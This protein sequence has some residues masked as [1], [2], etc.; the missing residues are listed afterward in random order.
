MLA[1]EDALPY[2]LAWLFWIGVIALV[3]FANLKTKSD[4]RSK[5]EAISD[6]QGGGFIGEA[7]NPPRKREDL[8]V[9]SLREKQRLL[10]TEASSPVPLFSPA[11]E[12]RLKG[13]GVLCVDSRCINEVLGSLDYAGSKVLRAWAEE[14]LR[15]AAFMPPGWEEKEPVHP[16]DED[17]KPPDWD[18]RKQAVLER[19]GFACVLCGE[20]VN[21]ESAFFRRVALGSY[22]ADNL[23]TLCRKCD[24]VAGD[25]AQARYHPGFVLDPRFKLYHVDVCGKAP[26]GGKVIYEEPV[27]YDQ[28]PECL[29]RQTMKQY[30]HIAFLR[31]WERRAEAIRPYLEA[32][33]SPPGDSA[34]AVAR[35]ATYPMKLYRL[36]G[37]FDSTPFLI[38]PDMLD[39][40]K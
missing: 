3:V 11:I 14:V 9:M 31:A 4:I 17:R 35:M 15:A 18:S 6:A 13:S 1:V 20:G 7:G 19:D 22:R 40:I 23:A 34:R 24:E 38:S 36:R 26:V 32:H 10:E 12:K 5:H 28:C 30:L 37:G 21:V 29:P 27:G 8:R 16:F 33:Y 39:E 2:V 25:G